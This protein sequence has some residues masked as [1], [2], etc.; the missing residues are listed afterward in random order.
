MS[1][2]LLL[3]V[4]ALCC[5]AC[6]NIE[7]ATPAK[8]NT[9]IR[10]YEA[11]HNLSGVQAEPYEDGYLILGNEELANGNFNTVIIRTNDRGERLGQD[12][13]LPDGSAKA[14]KITTDGYYVLGDS[15]KVNIESGDGSV[16][17]LIVSSTRLFKLNAS[18]NIMKKI[19]IADPRNQN[20]TDVF[21]SSLTTNADGDVIVLGTFKAA[22]ASA[23]EKPFLVSLDPVSLDTNWVKRYEVL[24]R[25]YVNS[26]A[27]HIN[28][29]GKII[30]ATA[31][32]KESGN[33][34]RS[35]IGVPLIP[36]NSTFENFS[37]YG[38]QTD[39][40]LYPKDIQPSAGNIYGV[41]GSYATP[42]GA[43]G[44]LFF[45]RV[46]QNGDIIQ[47]SER[48]FDGESL[49]ANNDDVAASASS[50]DDTGDAI[51]AT[52]DGGFVLA[53]S[54]LTTPNRGNG[55]KDILLIKVTSQ[56]EIIWNKI[57]GGAGDETVSSIREMADGGL[58]ICGS[59]NVSGLSSIF[60]IKTTANG[61]LKD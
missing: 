60:M 26:R 45:V 35:Y 41:V 23:T 8:R 25:D 42:A 36:E 61:E 17:D 21:G 59:N 11:P 58:L 38:E 50:S 22:A 20:I 57:L 49:L 31:L 3:I 54:M 14:L 16:F 6:Q 5:W 27:V 12:I 40:Q 1:S 56:G 9:F 44:N 7:D 19:V 47:G 24:D 18:G 29:D 33:F 34:A 32:L 55:G 43:N 28:P 13:V 4:A 51:I 53:G 39:Q 37:Q 2:R 46:S 48:Y 10:F 52:S 30:W 15:I